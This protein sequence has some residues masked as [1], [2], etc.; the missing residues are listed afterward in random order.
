MTSTQRTEFIPPQQSR[1]SNAAQR[2]SHPRHIRRTHEAHVYQNPTAEQKKHPQKPHAKRS[3]SNHAR[4]KK[5]KKEDEGKKSRERWIVY[6]TIS[7]RS[8]KYTFS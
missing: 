4:A 1:V 6:M 2:Y 3:F 8:S 5:S 7:I